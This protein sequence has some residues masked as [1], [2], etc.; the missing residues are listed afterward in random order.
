MKGKL[1]PLLLLLPFIAFSQNVSSLKQQITQTLQTEKLAGAVWSIVDSSGRIV[2]DAAGLKNIP[3]GEAMKPTDRVH[4]GSVTKPVLAAGILRLMTE[5]KLTMDAPVNRYL[6]EVRFDNPW[7]STNPVT[8]RHL[9]DNTSGLGDLRLWHFFSTTSIPDTP[10]ET[11]YAKDPAVLKIYAQPGTVFSYSNMGYTL[12]GMIIEAVTGQRYEN[13]LDKHLLRPLGMTQSTFH[14]V[15][16]TGKYADSRL[17]MGHFE[18]GKTAEAL[19]VYLRPAG[20]FTT[21]AYDM[22]LFLQFLMGDGTING[23]TFI[24]KK[25]LSN[26]GRPQGTNAVKNGLPHGYSCGTTVRDRHG[27]SGIYGLGSIIGYRA[28]IY[29]FPTDKKAF[30]ISYNMDSETANYEVFNQIF[31][32]HLGIQKQKFTDALSEVTEVKEWQGY[33]VPVVTKYEP[34]AWIDLLTGFTQL[35]VQDNKVFS[36]A[37]QQPAKGLRYTGRG[38]FSMEGRTEVS[39]VLY[40]VDQEMFLTDGL[41]T[42]R[43]ING[44]LI[45]GLWSSVS[46][47]VVGLVFVFFSGIYQWMRQKKAFVRKPI[48]AA[49]CAVLFLFVPVPF[50]LSQPFVSMGNQNAASVLLMLATIALPVGVLVSVVRFLREKPDSVLQKIDFWA[51]LLVLQWICLLACSGTIPFRLWA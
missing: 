31:I 6:P 32:N 17:A 51:F 23:Q 4:V 33:Y 21:T 44:W 40:R 8:V 50:F 38:R 11:F 41:K 49:F 24:D 29:L 19:P 7:E 1:L 16:Q 42:G 25:Y 35:T 15:S 30:F 5:G 12:L 27:V 14:F 13:Y 45:V 18:N 48:F 37:F 10:L 26:L 46:L 20:Q 3:M 22:A 47:G 39:H 2:T 9:L 34:F 28:T 43:K 36:Q